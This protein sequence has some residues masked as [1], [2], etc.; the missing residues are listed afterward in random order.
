MW[1]LPPELQLTPSSPVVATPKNTKSTRISRFNVQR[2]SLE[3]QF[4]DSF[5]PSFQMVNR[6]Q[7]SSDTAGAATWRCSTAAP[8]RRSAANEASSC[9]GTGSEPWRRHH[10]FDPRRSPHSCGSRK[11][12]LW[13]SFWIMNAFKWFSLSLSLFLHPS[14]TF[15]GLQFVVPRLDRPTDRW[16]PLLCDIARCRFACRISAGSMSTSAGPVEGA[17]CAP[18]PPTPPGSTQSQTETQWLLQVPIWLS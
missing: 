7:L 5:R 14:A 18:T 13:C 10:S 17:S 3:F 16:S 1:N 12:L 9:P 4:M 2:L 15:W 11:H 6:T 8:R